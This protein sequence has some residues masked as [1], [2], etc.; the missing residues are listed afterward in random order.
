MTEFCPTKKSHPQTTYSPS[1]TLL[2]YFQRVQV[3]SSK[4]LFQHIKT[5]TF[6]HSFGQYP[7]RFGVSWLAQLWDVSK[8]TGG[9]CHSRFCSMEAKCYHESTNCTDNEH[10]YTQM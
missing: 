3:T 2:Q 1:A 8:W 5:P 6:D 9:K 10:T 7:W 4:G